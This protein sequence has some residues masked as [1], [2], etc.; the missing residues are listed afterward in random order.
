[1]VYNVIGLMSGSSLDGLDIAY[2]QLE[3]IRGNWGYKILHAECLP[4]TDKWVYDLSHASDLRMA[5]FLKLNTRYGRYL[6]DQINDFINKYNLGH[7]HCAHWR[8]AAFWWL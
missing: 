2:V 8:Q 5:D 4:Y 6:G 1:M 3:E 7:P